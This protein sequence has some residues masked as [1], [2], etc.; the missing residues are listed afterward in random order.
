MYLHTHFICVL[1]PPYTVHSHV[2]FYIQRYFQM[3][4]MVKTPLQIA[5]EYIF[6]RLSCLWQ[7][8]NMVHTG[9]YSTLLLKYSVRSRAPKF[10]I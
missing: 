4:Y 8:S 6:L 5:I 2:C 3:W 1:H 7:F 9:F 10:L